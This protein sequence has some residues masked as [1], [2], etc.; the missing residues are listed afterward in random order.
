[1]LTERG[2]NNRRQIV[3]PVP[4]S[5]QVITRHRSRLDTWYV[6]SSN[7]CLPSLF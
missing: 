6:A 7:G 5:L 4:I 1:M 2:K 3:T